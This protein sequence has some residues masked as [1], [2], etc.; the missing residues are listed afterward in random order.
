MSD[1]NNIFSFFDIK[2]TDKR[3]AGNYKNQY[4]HSLFFYTLNQKPPS[5]RELFRF[6]VTL[7]LISGNVD[8]KQNMNRLL[9]I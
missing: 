1:F 6:I 5:V 7:S 4:L 3:I 8:K 2:N 9:R